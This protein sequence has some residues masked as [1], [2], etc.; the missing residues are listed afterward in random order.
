MEE[1]SGAYGSR[2]QFTLVISLT[3]VTNIRSYGPFGNPYH[4]DWALT[5]FRFMADEGSSIVGFHGRSGTLLDS[6]GVYTV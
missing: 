5:H 4:K 6:I 3:F 1:V 2:L